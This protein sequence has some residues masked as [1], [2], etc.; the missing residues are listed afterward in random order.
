LRILRILIFK[1]ELRAKFITGGGWE[2]SV[3]HLTL[4]IIDVPYWWCLSHLQFYWYRHQRLYS[5][6]P[7]FLIS[8]I[9]FWGKLVTF[10]L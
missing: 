4:L 2:I 1:N 8:G 7:I 5:R 6:C 10:T 9:R 3:F